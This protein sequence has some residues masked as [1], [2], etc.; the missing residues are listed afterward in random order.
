MRLL[1]LLNTHTIEN[2]RGN[3][4]KKEHVRKLSWN[5]NHCGRMH[6]S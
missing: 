5:E 2:K 3:K 6:E 1:A 4:N